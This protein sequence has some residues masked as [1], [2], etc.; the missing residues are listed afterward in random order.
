MICVTP[1]IKK[2]DRVN[3]TAVILS[4]QHIHPLTLMS[5]VDE[6]PTW[7][8]RT[9][10]SMSS[11]DALRAMFRK[12]FDTKAVASWCVW[13]LSDTACNG[14]SETSLAGALLHP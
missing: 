8:Y 6:I 2:F 12:N 4:Q 10:D 9:F 11:K 3:A 14:V 13:R 5:N 1:Q 7:K